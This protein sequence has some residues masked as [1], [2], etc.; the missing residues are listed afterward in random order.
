MS[1]KRSASAARVLTLLETIADHQPIGVRALAKLLD[2]DKSAIH[3]SLMTLADNG[4]IRN[5]GEPPVKWEVTAHILA[6]ALAAHGGSDLRKRARPALERLRDDTD[7]TVLLVVPDVRNFVVADVVES[8]QALRVVLQ[9]GTLVGAEKTA[10]GRAL[11]PFLDLK[12]QVELLGSEL[13]SQLADSFAQ[14]RVRGYAVSE[15]EV[16]PTTITVAAPIFDFHEQPV[17]AVVVSGPRER[18]T[19]SVNG[20]VAEMLVRTARELSR[21]AP[22]SLGPH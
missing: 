21:S 16:N 2:E 6:V 20:P 5:T 1:V 3:R 18:L 11:M 4:W 8:R 14:T 17:G 12:R 7:E 22:K 19:H 15:V 9:V 13:P 10:T